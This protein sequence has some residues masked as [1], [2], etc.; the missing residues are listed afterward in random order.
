MTERYL[1]FS[2]QKLLSRDRALTTA[3]R[4]YSLRQALV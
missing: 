4:C 2:G 1:T 3:S